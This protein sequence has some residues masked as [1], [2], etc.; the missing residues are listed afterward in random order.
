MVT[1][2]DVK[3]FAELEQYATGRAARS[4][5]R[6]DPI[7]WAYWQETY[8]WA[9][10]QRKNTP[11]LTD[12]E[13]IQSECSMYTGEAF[14]HWNKN[15]EAMKAAIAYAHAKWIVILARNNGI[16]MPPADTGVNLRW[17]RKM[18]G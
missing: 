3:T 2:S 1:K 13:W 6:N 5:K 10:G 7:A 11:K 14:F 9:A 18:A 8:R 15:H 12:R 4:L 17:L 16:K